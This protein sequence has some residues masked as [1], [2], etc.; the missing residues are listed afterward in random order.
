MQGNNVSAV[1]GIR[2]GDDDGEEVPADD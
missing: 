1:T 2:L